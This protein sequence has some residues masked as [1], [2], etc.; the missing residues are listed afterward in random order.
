MNKTPNPDSPEDQLPHEVVAALRERHGPGGNI[1]DSVSQAILANANSH[2]SQISR[3]EKAGKRSQR[4]RW[5]AWSSGTIAA[6][7]L[8]FALLPQDPGQLGASRSMVAE[9]ESAVMQKLAAD[10]LLSGDIDQSGRVDILDAFALARQVNSNS[11]YSSQWDQNGDGRMDQE[12][13]D[14]VALNAVTL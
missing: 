4:F 12:D 1:P 3:P 13:V 7:A 5:V 9:T 6:A 11:E 8:L 14:L 2:L 10:G